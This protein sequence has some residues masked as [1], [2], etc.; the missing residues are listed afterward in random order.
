MS[1]EQNLNNAETQ[2]LN[3]ADVSNRFYRKN[4][5]P[6]VIKQYWSK[7]PNE[8][9]QVEVD[10]GTS[11]NNNVWWVN[12]KFVNKYGFELFNIIGWRSLN[13]C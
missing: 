8:G 9:E 12:G 1:K 3:I 4:E 10:Y 6:L 7:E 11:T 2:Q 13:G 5:Y